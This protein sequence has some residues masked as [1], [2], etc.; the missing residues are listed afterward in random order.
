MNGSHIGANRK[1]GIR[2]FQTQLRSRLHIRIEENM[3][4]IELILA[5]YMN[6][7]RKAAAEKCLLTDSQ[8]EFQV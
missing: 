4:R 5:Y 2:L 6:E 8:I 3:F 1:F 7:L